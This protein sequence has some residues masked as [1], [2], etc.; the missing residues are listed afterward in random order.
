M[1]LAV[2]VSKLSVFSS[3]MSFELYSNVAFTLIAAG[4]IMIA[5]KKHPIEI[6]DSLNAY[7]PPALRLKEEE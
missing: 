1:V 2:A 7:L 6:R 5:L 3:V 4:V